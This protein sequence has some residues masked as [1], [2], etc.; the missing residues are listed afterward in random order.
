MRAKILDGSDALLVC[1]KNCGEGAPILAV[2]THN[3]L[4]MSPSQLDKYS[5]LASFTS[6]NSCK[7]SYF[8][9]VVYIFFAVFSSSHSCLVLRHPMLHLRQKKPW[10]PMEAAALAICLAQQ[11]QYS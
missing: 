10:R 5:L 4:S 2:Q 1:T 11:V 8:S 9:K 7:I 3:I 6:A